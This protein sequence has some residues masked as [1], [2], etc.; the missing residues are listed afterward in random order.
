MGDVRLVPQ[1]GASAG[2]TVTRNALVTTD[3]YQVKVGADGVWLNFVKVG[4]GAAN[5]IIVTPGTVNGLAI[6]DRTIVVAATTGD[7]MAKFMRDPY[8][9]SAGDLEFTV[10]EDTGIT[11]AVFYR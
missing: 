3:T 11:C 9:N 2:V 7:V 4:A 10:S 1:K 5:A 8:A 6:D